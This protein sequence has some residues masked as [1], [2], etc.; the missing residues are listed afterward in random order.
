MN[1]SV[2]GKVRWLVEQERRAAEMKHGLLK[3]GMDRWIHH[4]AEEALE[5]VEEMARIR[6]FRNGHLSGWQGGML[7]IRQH[8][9]V[10]LAQVI[11]LAETMM[12]MLLECKENEEEETWKS[13][14][15]VTME[16]QE[17]LRLLTT[18]K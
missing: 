5:A 16:M 14:R 3:G 15:E 8:L 6:D 7:E 18:E 17:Q 4:L 9:V 13:P 2:R 12:G 10:E 1:E 11:Q